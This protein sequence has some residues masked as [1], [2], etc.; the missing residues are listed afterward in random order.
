[1]SELR[2]N[3]ITRE[4]VI[5]AKER[6]KRPRDFK[7]IPLRKPLPEYIKGCPFCP[8]NEDKTPEE[9]FRL[10]GKEGWKIRVVP[11]KFEVLSSGG[12]KK[13]LIDGVKR[14]VAGVGKHEVIIESPRHNM[15]PALFSLEHTRD[16]IRIYRERFINAHSDPR[17]EHAIIFKN[18][19]EGAGTSLE[20][21]H[22][23]LIATPVVPLQFRDRIQAALHYFDDT[24]SCL[25]CD[26]LKMELKD[27]VR[28]VTDSEHFAT[29]IPYAALS[30]FHTWI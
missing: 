21:P 18:Y 20:H 13:W 14:T 29:F 19:G 6:A 24:G 16:I 17:V 11:N 10:E 26:V 9:S 12:E 1:M 15:S 5:I 28:V 4:W 25:V 30:P 3:V 27:S 7:G 2:L 22:S 23:Q 8:G